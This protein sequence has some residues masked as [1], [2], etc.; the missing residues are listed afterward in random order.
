M[1]VTLRKS[2]GEGGENNEN[3][4]ILVQTLL[5]KVRKSQGKRE[6]SVDGDAGPETIGAIRE[7][8]RSQFGWTGPQLDGRIDPQGNTLKNLNMLASPALVLLIEPVRT[9]R[10]SPFENGIPCRW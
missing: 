8:Q 7:F 1:R 10:K 3:E 2:V 5:S 9:I 6:I 4:V